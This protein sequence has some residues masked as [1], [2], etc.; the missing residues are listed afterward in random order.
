MKFICNVNKY[1]I[2][3][4]QNDLVNN[5]MYYFGESLIKKW[6]ASGVYINDGRMWDESLVIKNWTI[7]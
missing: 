4:S 1:W 6:R 3:I 5:K 7:V 2:S